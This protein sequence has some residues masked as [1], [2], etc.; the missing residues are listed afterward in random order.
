MNNGFLFWLCKQK[1]FKDIISTAATSDGS[2]DGSR[3]QGDLGFTNTIFFFFFFL[4]L[5]MGEKNIFRLSG[6][7]KE[8]L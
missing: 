2:N 1:T 5:G 6:K 7:E 4:Y 3:L 8:R